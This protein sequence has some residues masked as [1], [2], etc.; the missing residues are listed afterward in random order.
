MWSPDG[1]KVSF[2]STAPSAKPGDSTAFESFVASLE[3]LSDVHGIGPGQVTW[4]PDGQWLAY[5]EPSSGKLEIM[6]HD[7][8]ERR[9]L[10]T[11][12][13][14]LAPPSP[15]AAM[16]WSPD[17]QAIAYS[18]WK[19]ADVE[20]ETSIWLVDI[21]TAQRRPLLSLDEPRSL[22]QIAWS[23]EGSYLAVAVVPIADVGA[24]N[25]SGSSLWIV[26]TDDGQRKELL[27]ELGVVWGFAWNPSGQSIAFV[28]ETRSTRDLWLVDVATGNVEHLTAS[29]GMPLD[30]SWRDEATI[31]VDGLGASAV[32]LTLKRR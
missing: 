11:Q 6:R 23:P 10:V 8:S 15:Y 31:I 26:V 1:S 25:P 20:S 22:V 3:N 12:G 19:P 13:V 5:H 9:A 29:G 32:I 17:G 2:V 16:A 27:G 21:S 18:Q 14:G 28:Q 24:Q 30:V 4:S 7:G